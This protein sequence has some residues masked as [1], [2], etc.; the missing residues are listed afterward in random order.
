MTPRAVFLD[1]D[2]TINPDPGY[3]DAPEKFKLFPETIEAL[4]LLSSAGYLLFL[5]TNQSGIGRGYFSRETLAAIHEHMGRLLAGGGVKF[6]DLL[7]CPHQP[8]ENC[9]C[10]KPDPGMVLELA[11][12]HGVDREKSWF[13]GDKASDIICGRR[14]G[15]RTI[16]VRGEKIDAE[17]SPDFIADDLLGAARIITGKESR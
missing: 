4:R 13:V 12:R 3:I 10:R 11:R 6:D 5:V 8:G 17:V 2:G 14:A 7:Y 9:G 16:L 15:C 1:R